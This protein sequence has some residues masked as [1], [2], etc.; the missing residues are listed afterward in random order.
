MIKLFYCFDWP[1]GAGSVRT[2]IAGRQGV[3]MSSHI[4]VERRVNIKFSE[5]TE[6]IPSY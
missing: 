4:E 1:Q 2:N 3:Q 5:L 6:S